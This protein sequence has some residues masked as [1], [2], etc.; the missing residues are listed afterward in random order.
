MP[1]ANTAAPIASMDTKI[2]PKVMPVPLQFVGDAKQYPSS[3]EGRK[4]HKIC[5]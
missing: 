1:D 2:F 5:P 3:G 4:R